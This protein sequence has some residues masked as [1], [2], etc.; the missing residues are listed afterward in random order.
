MSKLPQQFTP[1]YVQ[2]LLLR[3]AGSKIIA[4]VERDSGYQY[5]VKIR[6]VAPAGA[7]V[8]VAFTAK[9]LE[10]AAGAI[11][12]RSFVVPVGQSEEFVVSPGQDLVARSNVN[13]VS[14]SISVGVKWPI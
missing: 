10:G 3:G 14:V 7:L 1:D 13:D 12:G 5:R 2:T 8:F 11:P 9:D 4:S 6:G